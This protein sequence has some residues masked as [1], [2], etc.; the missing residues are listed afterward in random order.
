M[1]YLVV[2]LPDPRPSLVVETVQDAAKSFESFRTTL[3]AHG[4]HAGLL[5]D[6]STCI[7]VRDTHMSLY[8]D[9]IVQEAS[10]ATEAL[11]GPARGRAL[12]QRVAEWLRQMA[13]DWDHTLSKEPSVAAALLTDVVPALSGSQ[14][15]EVRAA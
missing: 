14:I 7:V 3:L 15:T 5:F 13:A 6:A 2:Q 10:L 11:L 12:D 4:C 9:S 1:R 8:E